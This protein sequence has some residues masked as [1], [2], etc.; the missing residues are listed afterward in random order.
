MQDTSNV[1]GFPAGTFWFGMAA[2]T[3]CA[4]LICVAVVYLRRRIKDKGRAEQN[5][6]RASVDA[7]DM[8]RRGQRSFS[9]AVAR[10]RKDYFAYLLDRT[11]L[12][13][14]VRREVADRLRKEYGRCLFRPLFSVATS[15]EKG[16]IDFASI[17]SAERAWLDERGQTPAREDTGGQIETALKDEISAEVDELVEKSC[18]SRNDK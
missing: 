14:N 7:S 5:E 16:R 3:A 9:D 4:I 18:S 12:Q 13:R 17:L 8:C 2:G 10:F 15:D 1:M 6:G 11:L